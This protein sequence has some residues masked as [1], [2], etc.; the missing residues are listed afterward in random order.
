MCELPDTS[1]VRFSFCPRVHRSICAE[2]R[3]KRGWSVYGTNRREV[4]S[5]KKVSRPTKGL[6]SRLVVSHLS[7]PGGPDVRRMVR[8]FESVQVLSGDSPD[9]H[10][11]YYVVSG[12]G[13]AESVVVTRH[14]TPYWTTVAGPKTVSTTTALLCFSY[15]QAGGGGPP[16]NM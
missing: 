6:L 12:L 10:H 9:S 7:Q 2:Q 8:T 5:D 3:A 13:H 16:A 4:S 11:V 1:S 14:L 15:G